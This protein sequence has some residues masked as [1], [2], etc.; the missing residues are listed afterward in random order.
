M[1]AIRTASDPEE[2]ERARV[3]YL[4]RS[5]LVSQAMAELRDLPIEEKPAAGQTGNLVKRELETTL[6]LRI[7]EIAAAASASRPAASMDL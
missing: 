7:S 4:G 2:I 6:E 5:G 1:A 3:E